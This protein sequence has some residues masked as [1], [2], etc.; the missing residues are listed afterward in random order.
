MISSDGGDNFEA[1]G[2]DRVA[3]S[4]EVSGE[5]VKNEDDRVIDN[6]RS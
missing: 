6:W 4:G 3:D 5:K 1:I 2:S